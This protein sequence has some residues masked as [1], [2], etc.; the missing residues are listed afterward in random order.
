MPR[1]NLKNSDYH[2]QEMTKVCKKMIEKWEKVGLLNQ[3]LD[4]IIEQ[5]NNN[6]LVKIAKWIKI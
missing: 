3:E 4:L 1:L 5:M 6:L 2:Y